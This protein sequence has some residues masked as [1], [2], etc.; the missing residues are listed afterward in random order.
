MNE[1]ETRAE[2]IDPKLKASGWGAVEGTKVH[3][4]YHITAGKI[5]VGGKRAK[6][7][8]ADY[9]LS[10]KGRKLAA[11]EAKSEDEPV[12]KGVGQAKNYAEK[13][14]LETT[15]ACNGKEIYQIAMLTGKEGL[16]QAFPTPDELWNRTF[17]N[18][19]QLRDQFTNLPLEDLGGTKSVRYY[20]EIA[21][22]N[23]MAAIADG[24]QRI[25]LTLARSRGNFSR[26]AGTLKRMAPAGPVSYSLRTAIYWQTR[27]LT[28]FQRSPKTRWCA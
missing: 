20:Q 22:N 5:L 3:R 21:V 8:I 4:E 28:L 16:I 10:Y 17:L 11:M 2:L 9:V 14:H 13:M 15:F 7:L 25:L 23:T 27:L 1:A 18:A 12:S 26:R 19:D 24:K 6:P